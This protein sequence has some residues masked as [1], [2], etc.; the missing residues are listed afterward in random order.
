MVAVEEIAIQNVDYEALKAR[1][2]NTTAALARKYSF[3]LSAIQ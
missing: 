2:A 1:K 3:R